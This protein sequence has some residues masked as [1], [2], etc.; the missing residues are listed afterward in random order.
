M[1]DQ[2]G[3]TPFRR[4]ARRDVRTAAERRRDAGLSLATRQAAPGARRLAAE[5]NAVAQLR[6]R[7]AARHQANE[8]LVAAGTVVPA[9]ITLALD[10]RGLDGPEVDI[11]CGTVEPYVDLWE[12]GLEIPTEE[13]VRLLAD[14]TG[15]PVPFFYLPIKPG[16]LTGPMF[17]CSDRKCE[18][19]Q[20]S[21]VDQ[22]GVLHY[23]GETRGPPA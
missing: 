19:I 23:A 10:L 18:V 4:P 2:D 5:Q 3:V 17:L 6:H 11:A 9:R 8:R 16:P 21:I 1:T 22:R 7:I 20:P 13:Q 14:L 12:C 15:F